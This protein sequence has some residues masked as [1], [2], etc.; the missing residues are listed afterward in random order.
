[1]AKLREE[2]LNTLLAQLLDGHD[3][4]TATPEA[5]S[6]GAAIDITAR[7]AGA[8]R[9]APILMEAKTGDT[10]AN[11]RAAARQARSRLTDR[12]RALAFALCYPADLRRDRPAGEAA[13]AMAIATLTFAPVSRSGGEPAWRKGSAADL[14]AV[15]L[16][17]DLS[18]G[19]VA[20]AI[21]H[22]VREAADALLLAGRAPALAD[23]LAL[24]RTEKERRATA[25]IAALMLSNAALLHHRLRLVPTL[26]EIAPLE[27]ALRPD[28][29][30]PAILRE[31]WAAVLGIDYHPVFAPAVA[32]LGALPDEDA[33]EP[34][35][36][37]V[38]NAVAVAD[39][40]ASLRFDH[41]GPLYHRLL[42][43][44]RFDGSFYTNNVSALLLA[45][46]AMPEDWADW[47]DAD[48]LSRLRI[49]DPACGTGTLLMAA[50]HTIRD[51]HAEAAGPGTD[52]DPLHLAMVEDVLHGFDINRHGVQLAACNLTLGNPRVDY[53]RMNLFTMRHGPQPDGGALAGSLELLAA[54]RDEGDLLSLVSPL[55]TPEGLGA[56][57]AQPDAA[58]GAALPKTFDL[59]IMNPPFTRDDIRN[60][61]YDRAAQRALQNREGR[62][63]EIV[64]TRDRPAREAIDRT[65]VATYFSPLAD[66]LSRDRSGRGSATVAKVIPATA[67]VN[68]SGI[69]ER[70]FLAER[71]QIETVVT[72]HDPDRI[73]FS[74]DTNIHESLLI[75]RRPGPERAATR[76]VSLARMPRDAHEA[77]LLADRINRRQPLGEWGTERDWPWPRVRAGDWSAAQ[78]YDG[79]LAEAPRDLA[80]LAEDYLAPAG[81]LCEMEPDGRSIRLAFRRD[82]PDGAPWTAPIL[83][84]HPTED[85]TTMAARA[86]TRAAPKPGREDYARGLAGKASRLLVANRIYTHRVSVTACYADEPM[87]GSAWMPVTPRRPDPAF[88]KAL[89]AWWNSTPG[90]LTFIQARARKLTY[91]RYALHSLRGLLVP[92]PAAAD[93]ALLAEA[94]DEVGGKTLL[95]WPRMHECPV[96]ARLDLAAA[97][98]VRLDG[99]VVADWRERI[100]R[101]PTVSG[102]PIRLP[103]G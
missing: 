2:S 19:V 50:M 22:T 74:E 31:A 85:R 46:L 100:A 94:F 66:M 77:L 37:I 71:F 15:L 42:A 93:T 53:R 102:R 90:V 73:N 59:V 95:P 56:E 70:R 35:R 9:P 52:A 7:H 16:N 36:L 14:A 88:E 33:R 24:P 62:I 12:P 34:L 87:L 28:G 40:L 27:A 64:E 86:D 61:Q 72:S 6:G 20:E 58:P 81:E 101:E 63:A 57:R 51:R 41:A 97:R 8:A 92:N 32:A 84:N 1:M 91:P 13:A 17:A 76:F 75:A 10:A 67:L 68:A 79:A 48:A 99:R 25:L 39:D 43:S 69:P 96:R 30:G 45:R 80:A 103:E 47:T 23:A 98:A 83:W 60:R 5:R 21:E 3:G 38:E 55:P 54:A 89:C 65:S 18:R 49:V 44:A 29:G 82:A 11:R 78:F 26:A 4:L